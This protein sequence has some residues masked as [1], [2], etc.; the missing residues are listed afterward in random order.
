MATRPIKIAT[1]GDDSNLKKTLKRLLCT[2]ALRVMVAG[3]ELRL[4]TPDAVPRRRLC[5]RVGRGD[6][7]MGGD[8][9]ITP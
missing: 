2:P 7:L 3:R 1:V 5:L 4:A 6:D 9:R 8:H